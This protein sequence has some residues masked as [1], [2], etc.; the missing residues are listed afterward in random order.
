MV[1][2]FKSRL[3]ILHLDAHNVVRNDKSVNYQRE[4]TLLVRNIAVEAGGRKRAVLR[5]MSTAKRRTPNAIAAPIP[6]LLK[7]FFRHI[8]T[9]SHGSPR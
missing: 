5:Y 4:V 1:G 3:D 8:L 2:I 9:F 6:I 7:D